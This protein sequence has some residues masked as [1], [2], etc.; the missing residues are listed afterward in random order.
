VFVNIKLIKLV[1]KL[2]FY[3]LKCHLSQNQKPASIF[4][5]CVEK[6]T[7]HYLFA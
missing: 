4:V 3:V 1:H 7:L 6:Q 5:F 2:F